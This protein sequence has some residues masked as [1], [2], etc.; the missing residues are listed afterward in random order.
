MRVGL[1]GEN[2]VRCN[3]AAN[4]ALADLLEELGAEVWYPSLS[5]WVLYTNWT[6]RLHCRYEGQ[7]KREL[8][9]R[10]IDALQRL[11]MTRLTR[12]VRGRLA[13]AAHPAV[14]KL[15]E[16]AAPYVPETF[17]GETIVGIGRTIDLFNRG[18][19]GDI[20][21][22]PFGCMVGG[23]VEALCRRVS[24]DLAGFPILHL[25]Y[26][27]RRGLHTHGLLEGFVMRARAWQEERSAGARAR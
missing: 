13:N 19:G 8:R 5:E 6:A 18:V 11:E 15:F 3:A 25:Q 26:D 20:N 2:Y 22:A 14:T 27:G 17:E 10:A 23:I 9:L 7:W 1:L 4:A 24:T 21:V 12:A 16:L